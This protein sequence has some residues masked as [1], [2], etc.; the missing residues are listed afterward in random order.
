VPRTEEFQKRLES[1]VTSLKEAG[2]KFMR[3]FL[4]RHAKRIYLL[5]EA[6]ILYFKVDRTLVF[7]I[8]D[9]GEYWINYTLA[10]IESAVDPAFSCAPIANTSST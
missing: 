7:V 10:E 8:A 4:A 5:N 1:M 6:D 9:S 2:P 3:R